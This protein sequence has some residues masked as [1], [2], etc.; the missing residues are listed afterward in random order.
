MENKITRFRDEA[1]KL[2]ESAESLFPAGLFKDE[3]DGPEISIN[4]EA[5]ERYKKIAYGILAAEKVGWGLLRI[6]YAEAP[7]MIDDFSTV[8][9]TIPKAC[10]FTEK[11]RTA[12]ALAAML[13][14]SITTT[15]DGD[16]MWIN[17]TVT[18]IWT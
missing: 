15:T 13:A 5:W 18:D 4:A 9:I 6:K 1:N 10:T 11:A 14:D 3:N 8:T 16:K 17:F 7:S 2:L 12:F